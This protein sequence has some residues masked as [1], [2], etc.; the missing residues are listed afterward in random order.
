MRQM[1]RRIAVGCAS[2]FCFG[3]VMVFMGVSWKDA[4]FASKGTGLWSILNA[5]ALALADWWTLA[6]LPPANEPA[7]VV[8]PAMMVLAQW[9][10]IGLLAGFCFGMKAHWM[11]DHN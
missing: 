1:T 6:G 9:V 11:H 4:T 8:T 10:L 3:L 2:G 5:P 7:W